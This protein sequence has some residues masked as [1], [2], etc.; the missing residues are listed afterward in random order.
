MW[1]T[2]GG[3]GDRQIARLRPGH[4]GCAFHLR[5]AHRFSIKDA[6]VILIWRL[7]VVEL[8][9]DVYLEY[10]NRLTSW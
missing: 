7:S 10:I 9:Q 8:L 6:T 3:A 5:V 4:S 2:R 1:T